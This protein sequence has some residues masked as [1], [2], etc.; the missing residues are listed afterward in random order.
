MRLRRFRRWVFDSIII[1]INNIEQFIDKQ[2]APL[3]LHGE[4][5]ICSRPI[6]IC[7]GKLKP[8]P[9]INHRNDSASQIEQTKNRM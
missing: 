2:A 5:N 6:W 8:S 9:E 7:F 3:S 1:D 4:N